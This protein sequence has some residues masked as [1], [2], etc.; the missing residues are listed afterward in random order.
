M[1]PSMNPHTMTGNY[2]PAAAAAAAAAAGN[3]TGRTVYVGNLPA[4]QSCHLPAVSGLTHL[5]R[6]LSMTYSISYD[7]VLS[8]VFGYSAR[9]PVFSSLSWT[10]RPLLPFTPMLRSRSLHYMVRSFG[11]AGAS[12]RPCQPMSLKRYHSIRQPAMSFSATSPRR[13]MSRSCGTSYP[14]S[15]RSIRSRL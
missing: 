3:T 8:R 1:S 5:Q 12:H 2:G 14:S 13:R 15:V 10:A 9:N 6:L 4:G 7:S 11:S